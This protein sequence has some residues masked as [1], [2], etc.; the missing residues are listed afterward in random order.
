MK[1]LLILSVIISCGFTNVSRPLISNKKYNL[2]AY[3]LCHRLYK[4]SGH[5]FQ[6]HCTMVL[7]RYPLPP[8][9]TD[10][11][12]LKRIFELTADTGSDIAAVLVL[13]HL[14][15]E[16][17]CDYLA[18]PDDIHEWRLKQKDKEIR[19]WRKKLYGETDQ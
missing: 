16:Q 10:P 14:T 7:D 12:D 9:G 8:F 19:F 2:S 11:E 1:K 6:L 13:Y 17:S 15:Q 4:D 18:M 5:H 3:R